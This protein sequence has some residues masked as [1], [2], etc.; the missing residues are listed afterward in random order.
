MPTFAEHAMDKQFADFIMY[1]DY[2]AA[3][4]MLPQFSSMAKVESSGRH[5]AMLF[6]LLDEGCNPVYY[7]AAQSSGSW[8]PIITFSKTMVSDGNENS[9][10]E[11]VK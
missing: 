8:N 5:L 10:E 2:R 9:E 6:G 1:K 11:Y 3:Y 4:D 7:A